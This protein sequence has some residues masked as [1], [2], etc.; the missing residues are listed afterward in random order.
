MMRN[1]TRTIILAAALVIWMLVIFFFSAQPSD[2]SR[3][4][5]NIFTTIA[6]KIL[7]PNFEDL[8]SDK[9]LVIM[10]A[11]SFW[12]RK[13]AHFTAYFILG[14]LSFFNVIFSKKLSFN[15]RAILAF[16]LCVLYAASDEIHQYFVPGRSCEFRDVCIDSSGALLSI[17]IAFLIFRFSKKLYNSVKR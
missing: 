11:L 16:G 6:Q 14:A 8:S 9:Q 3:N 12:V 5:S 10:E 15:L 4:T 7:Y 17:L 2:D 13:A 1:K